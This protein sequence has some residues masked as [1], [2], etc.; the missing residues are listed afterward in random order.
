MTIKPK[1]LAI[2]DEVFNLDIISDYLT[3]D[4]YEV[5]S[6]EDGVLG[7]KALEENPDVDVIILDRMMPNMNGMEVLEVL[8]THKKFRNIPVIMQTAAASREQILEGIIAG[9]YYYLPKPFDKDT[10]LSIVKLA[11][12]HSKNIKEMSNEV[13]N[14]KRSIG[15]METSRFRIRTIEEARNLAYYIATCFPNPQMAVYG[16]SE[17]LINAIEHGNLGLT[18]SDKTHL[19]LKGA[20]QDE[21]DHRLALPG[22]LEKYAYLEFEDTPE[23]ITVTIKDAGKGFDWKR[24]FLM[25]TDRASDPNGRG[26]SIAKMMSFSNVE[27]KGCGNEVVCT[28]VKN[29]PVVE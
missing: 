24:Y 18:Y 22:N 25:E 15:V 9:V 20:L 12:Q 28:V 4:G 7:M 29:P 17:M 26:I 23:K 11:A 6:A 19:I 14:H 21:I 3:D 8:H 5:V 13:G 2:D 1:I 27:Y 10:L 16:L